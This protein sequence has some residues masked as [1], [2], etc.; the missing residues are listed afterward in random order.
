MYVNAAL[1]QLLVDVGPETYASGGPSD[2]VIDI[3]QAAAP[4]VDIVAPDIY[5]RDTPSYDAAIT[6]YSKFG[7]PLFVPETG[8]DTEFAR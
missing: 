7:N 4:A 1:R 8:A 2:N 3:Y 6:L 5:N